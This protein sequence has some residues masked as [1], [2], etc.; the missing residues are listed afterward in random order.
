MAVAG[1][2][3]AAI[4]HFYGKMNCVFCAFRNLHEGEVKNFNS[5]L[6]RHGRVLVPTAP[7]GN[8]LFRAIAQQ[9]FDTEER[10]ADVRRDCTS[11]LLEHEA[12]L[13]PFLAPGQ[14]SLLRSTVPLQMHFS[15]RDRRLPPSRYHPA[16]TRQSF[17]RYVKLMA[18]DGTWGGHLEMCALGRAY[19]C[20]I[21]VYRLEEEQ[22]TCVVEDGDGGEIHLG[23]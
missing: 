18:R 12:E 2:V 8:C 21:W 22:P 4:T 1:M 3:F 5:L 11:F 15:P 17:Q 6:A 13:L 20:K 19:R 23:E 14:C 7:D 9:V 10:H 16:G